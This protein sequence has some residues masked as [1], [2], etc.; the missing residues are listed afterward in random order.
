MAI[1]MIIIVVII[2]IIIIGINVIRIMKFIVMMIF[3][4]NVSLAI[5]LEDTSFPPFH[6]L[7]GFGELMN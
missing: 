5:K 4:I 3:M 7:A 2:I 1:I 6:C